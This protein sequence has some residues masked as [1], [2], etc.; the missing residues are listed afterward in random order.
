MKGSAIGISGM[1][2]KPIAGAFD[3]ASKTAEGLTNTATYFD[4]RPREER[5]RFI[6]AFYES[7]RYIK[8]YNEDDAELMSKYYRNGL[9][10]IDSFQLFDIELNKSMLLVVS[11]NYLIYLNK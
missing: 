3:A 4:D 2:I 6:R 9:I 7:G 10:L 1:V 8:A 11:E 5:M